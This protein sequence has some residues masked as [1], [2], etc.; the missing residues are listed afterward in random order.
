MTNNTIVT[1][2]NTTLNMNFCGS[3]LPCGLCMITNSQCP[4]MTTTYTPTCTTSTNQD[5]S[6]INI[7]QEKFWKGVNDFLTAK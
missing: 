4:M 6:T 7:E 1:T 3:R 2:A 5:T